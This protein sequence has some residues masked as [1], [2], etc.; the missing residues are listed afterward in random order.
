MVFND[1]I[2]IFGEALENYSMLE[3]NKSGMLTIKRE[4]PTPFFQASPLFSR[5]LPGVASKARDQ[6]LRSTAHGLSRIAFENAE[7]VSDADKQLFF[8]EVSNLEGRNI[9]AYRS[10]RLECGLLSEADGWIAESIVRWIKKTNLTKLSSDR[11]IFTPQYISSVLP[12]SLQWT[13][14]FHKAIDLLCWRAAR[15]FCAK[16][17]SRILPSMHSTLQ[18][19]QR[20]PADCLLISSNGRY[21]A[22]LGGHR[23]YWSGGTLGSV[24]CMATVG[25]W[26]LVE[27]LVTSKREELL[28]LQSGSPVTGVSY[29]Q[30]LSPA[31]LAAFAQDGSM[32][33]AWQLCD[34]PLGPEASLLVTNHGELVLKNES[35]N[36][37]LFK[38][39]T[40]SFEVNVGLHPR[41]WPVTGFLYR[42]TSSVYQDAEREFR[43]RL[44]RARKTKNTFIS[45]SDDEA[46]ALPVLLN[47][48]LVVPELVHA[49]DVW[50]TAVV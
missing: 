12:N 33:W 21:A 40:A 3:E 29:T 2:H 44:P 8:D 26:M 20:L 35:C 37:A 28:W 49:R 25:R 23:Q 47:L 17:W 13:Q 14:H 9:P 1:I 42:Y 16:Y 41:K 34:A 32:V 39:T 45:I 48:G 46:D 50:V 10:P 11:S 43:R 31:I 5:S 22:G 6:W 4:L 18:L 15:Y 24:S 19:G 38:P 7:F 27:H 36:V 30:L